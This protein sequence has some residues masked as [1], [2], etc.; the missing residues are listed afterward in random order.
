M[1][2]PALNKSHFIGNPQIKFFK[3]YRLDKNRGQGPV[4]Q[5]DTTCLK[6]VNY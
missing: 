1:N 3:G 2:S 4:A 5:Q 6:M